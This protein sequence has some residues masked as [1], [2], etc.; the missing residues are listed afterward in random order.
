MKNKGIRKGVN[1]TN[2]RRIGK[3]RRSRRKGEMKKRK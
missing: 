3:G 2:S 1:G